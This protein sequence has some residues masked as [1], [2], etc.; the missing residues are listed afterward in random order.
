MVINHANGQVVF[1]ITSSNIKQSGALT[2]DNATTVYTA[3]FI[4]VAPTI[5][6]R[7]SSNTLAKTGGGTGLAASLF[8]SSIIGTGGGLINVLNTTPNITLSNTPQ[9]VYSSVLSVLPG[10][11]IN[12]RYSVMP[13]SNIWLAGVYTTN[14]TFGISGINPGNISPTTAGLTVN[15]DAFIEATNSIANMQLTVNSLSYYRNTTLSANHDFTVTTTVPYGLRLK[16]NAANFSYTNG[17]T[18]APDPSTATNLLTAQMSTPVS[19]NAV[20]PT[21]S[22]TDLTAAGLSVPSGNQQ[23]NTISV[24]IS[25][26]N[27][28]TGFLQQGTYSATLNYELFDSQQFPSATKK[29]ITMP[30]TLVVNDMSELKVNHTDVNLTYS[31]ATDYANGIYTDV[32][33]HVTFSK[34]T[35]YD[36]YV[37]ANASTLTNGS[38]SLP[39]DIITLS[40][41][42]GY[43]GSFNTVNLSSTSQKLISAAAPVVDKSL[44][45]RYAIPNTK[46]SQLLGKAAGTYST[47]VTYSIIAP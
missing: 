34:T 15:V 22:F 23:T 4:G 45:V 16:T 20:S 14:L 3:P 36:V 39:V 7:T 6:L 47:V 28:K 10:G 43:A 27:L 5:S 32:T 44:N 24:G 30:L 33:N 29:V 19:G 25:P 35:A 42:P 13:S 9:A 46:T 17:Y 12:F 21:A 11:A 1:N 2:V 26:V 8:T 31:N 37:K 41:S 40:P 38:N 18:G